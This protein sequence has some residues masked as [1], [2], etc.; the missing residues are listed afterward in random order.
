MGDREVQVVQ[1]GDGLVR[2]LAGVDLLSQGLR[3]QLRRGT[4]AAA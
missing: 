2:D 4:P 1:S 3:E